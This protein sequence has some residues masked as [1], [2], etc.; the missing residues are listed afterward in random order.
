VAGHIGAATSTLS[1]VAK[2]LVGK[3]S[4]RGTNLLMQ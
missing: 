1:L 4:T 3:P 2:W